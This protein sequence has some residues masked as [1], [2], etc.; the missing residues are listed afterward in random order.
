VAISPHA[1]P[2]DG[3][4][5]SPRVARLVERVTQRMA[6]APS[7]REVRDMADRAMRDTGGGQMTTDQ[8]RELANVALDRALAVE[9]TARKLADLLSE[10]PG[11]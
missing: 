5:V 9:A 6:A 3:H 2:E 4:Q 10:V 11:G 1:A 7:A 8:I